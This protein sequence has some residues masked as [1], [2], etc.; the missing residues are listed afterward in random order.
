MARMPPPELLDHHW[1]YQAD[2]RFVTLQRSIGGLGGG[3]E[4]SWA[5]WAGREVEPY[6][7][8]NILPPGD[9]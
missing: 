1:V 7:V 4:G 8:D 9:D 3:G 5:A 2:D 6:E